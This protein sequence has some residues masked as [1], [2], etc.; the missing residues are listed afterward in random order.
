VQSN[1]DTIEPNAQGEVHL[2]PP[3]VVGYNSNSEHYNWKIENYESKS[4]DY[5]SI[6]SIPRKLVK[7]C[8]SILTILKVF[9]KKIREYP[10][11]I[12]TKNEPTNLPM[13]TYKE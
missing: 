8:F 12:P 10:S 2:R 9:E 11:L 1:E 6:E 3:I 4:K 5:W 7:Q 13:L